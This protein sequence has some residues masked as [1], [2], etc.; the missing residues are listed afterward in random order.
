MICH[1]LV[2]SFGEDRT[3]A[4]CDAFLAEVRKICLE[5]GMTSQVEARP[6]LPLPNDAY[7]QT[8]VSSAIV[9]IFCEDL[10]TVESLSGYDA[11]V[12]FEH[13]QQQKPYS[14]V[15]INHEPITPVAAA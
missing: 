6:H 3:T 9:Q 2:F 4:E 10:D 1:T 11:L 7:A 13:D 12:K 5:S 8:F 14:V 15:W